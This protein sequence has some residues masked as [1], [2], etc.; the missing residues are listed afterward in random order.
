MPESV[1]FNSTFVSDDL[2]IDQ[3]SDDVVKNEPVMWLE[4]LDSALTNLPDSSYTKLVLK[5]FND[6]FRHY[7]KYAYVDSKVQFMRA[8]ESP[9]PN[10][11]WHVDG[12][13]AYEPGVA[14]ASATVK[15]AGTDRSKITLGSMDMRA[16]DAIS[17]L[18]VANARFVSFLTGY[19]SRTDIVMG[20]INVPRKPD[21]LLLSAFNNVVEDQKPNIK[22]HPS[23]CLV[24]YD[25]FMIHRGVRAIMDGWR[26]WIRISEVDAPISSEYLDDP[27][28]H[29]VVYRIGSK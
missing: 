14:N 9:T 29:S 1:S 8:G 5:R 18:G 20:D 6:K 21:D 7:D 26:L 11:W 28:S 10:N 17:I 27:D 15:L 19:C 4:P 23:C 3:P 24:S 12:T 13:I 2:T 16:Y 25:G 22:Q